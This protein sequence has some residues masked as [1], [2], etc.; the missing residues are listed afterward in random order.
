[1]TSG[2][3]YAEGGFDVYAEEGATAYVTGST[4]PIGSSHDAY[5]AAGP[6]GSWWDPDCA[7]WNQYSLE[8]TADHWYLRYTPTGESPMSGAMNWSTMFAAE[9]DLGTQD[10]GHDGSAAHGGGGGAWDWDCGWGVEVIPL[11]LSRFQASITDIGG[12]QYEVRLIPANLGLSYTLTPGDLADGPAFDNGQGGEPFG[13]DPDMPPPIG[14]WQAGPSG[15]GDSSFWS[16]V[17][18]SAAGGGRDYTSLRLSPKDIFGVS[19]VTVGDLANILYYTKN[20]DTDLIDWQVKIYTESEVKWYGYRINYNRPDNPDNDWHQTSTDALGISDIYD[21]VT[22]AYIS[23]STDLDAEKIL[24]VDIIAGYAT[25]SPAVDSYLDGVRIELNN[26]DN[27]IL[28]LAATATTVWVDDN[29]CDGCA[30]DGHIWGYDA[31]DNIQDGIDAVEGST[32]NVANGTYT[33]PVSITGKGVTITGESEGGVIV[34]ADT[35]QTGSANVFTIDADGFDITLENMTIRHGD[36]GIRSSAGNV[37]VL[38]CTLKHNGWDGTGVPETPTQSDMATFWS[39]YATDGGAI[40]IEN[41]GRSEIAYC[42]VYENDR[43]IRFQDGSNGDI[44]DNDTYNNIESGIYLAASSYTGATGCSDTNIYDNESYGNMEHGILSIGGINNTF[45]NNNL[46]DNWN[47]GVRL[48]HVADNSIQNNNTI[49]N[50]VLYTFNGVGNPSDADAGVHVSGSDIDSGATFVAALLN[51][52]FEDNPIQVQDDIDVLDIADV[53]AQNNFD[54]AVTVDHPGSSLLPTIWSS[55]QDGVDAAST[56]DTVQVAAGTYTEAILIEKELTLRGAT[57]GVN[58]NGYTV[59][60][61]YAWD[62][63]VESIINH[64]NP[65]GGYTTIV[66]IHDVDNVTFD[67]FVVQELNAEANKNSSLIRVYAHTREISNINVINNIIG[68]NTNTITQDGKQGRMGLYIVNHPYDDKG[69][70]NSTFAGNKI[71]DCKGNGDNVFLWTSYYAYGAPGPASMVGTVIEDNEIYGSHRSGIE[72]AGG[73]SDLTIRGNV[74]YGNSGLPADD[75]DFL[76]YGHGIQ[77]IRGSSDKVSDPVTAYGP[78]NL[79]IEYNEIYG[80][81]KNG[82]YMGPKNESITFTGNIIH[83][84]GWDGIML[85]L[86]GNYWNPTF[87]DPPVSYQYACYDCSNNVVASNNSIYNNGTAGNP[88]AKYGVQVIGVPTNS[89]IFDAEYNYW[90]DLSGPYDPDGVDETNGT[91]CYDPANMKNANGEGDSVSDLNVDYCPWLISAFSDEDFDGV[92]DDIDNCHDT[93]NGPVFGTCIS[94][95]IGDH[96]LAN[97]HCGVQGGFCSM[98]QEDNDQDGLGDVCDDDIDGDEILNYDDSC[99]LAYNPEQEDNYPPSG[100]YCGDA[101]ECEGNFDNDLDV[102]GDDLTTFLTDSGRSSWVDPC[103]GADP[104]NG[105]FDCDSDVDG[106]DLTLFLADSGRS[107]WV[108]PCPRDCQTGPWCTYP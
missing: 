5:S 45:T 85:D 98:D 17:Q 13:Y 23:T 28:D 90:G 32:V 76:K 40:R 50:N 36:Y 51:N 22:G 71:F 10:G 66:D 69:V 107:S 4:W 37:N 92:L 62:D 106:D 95:N 91:T 48:W 11:E 65:S 70:V 31:F 68:P 94:G 88:I 64:P 75:P 7:D 29:Y 74:I 30:N 53:L 16:D 96:C 2:G 57:A 21:K 86:E 103:T 108:N 102:D 18:G 80:N 105:D 34:Q 67:G 79:T 27:A 99:P 63:T 47:G 60:P 46:H 78:V 97:F 20:M 24:F 3:F 41:S 12:G 104:C 42:T 83:D 84:N 61:N 39:T 35:S 8:L 81:E 77:L 6:W 93:P 1:M 59:P 100:N 44:H 55:I 26:G 58:K 43:G 89:F 33:E 49:K 15:F 56:G 82:V 87:E 19:D 52:T 38:N 54:R 101:C 9:T 14:S 25:D 72:T 73:F